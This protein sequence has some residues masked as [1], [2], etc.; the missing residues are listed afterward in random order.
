MTKSRLLKYALLGIAAALIAHYLIK[1]EEKPKGHPRD[2][3]EIAARSEERRV[4]KECT[5]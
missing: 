2:Y 4:G 3:A 5:G 1:K